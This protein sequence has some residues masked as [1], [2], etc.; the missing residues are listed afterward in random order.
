MGLK[1]L[2]VSL[3][4]YGAQSL[5]RCLGVNDILVLRIKGNVI[6]SF[7]VKCS[8]IWVHRFSSKVLARK[9]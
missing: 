4:S 9:F 2:S 8:T 5:V 7:G 6:L 1:E 3:A